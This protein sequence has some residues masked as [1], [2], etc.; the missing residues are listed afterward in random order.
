MSDIFI[1]I[2]VGGTNFRLGVVQ[3]LRVIWEKRF[4]ADFSG[5]CR[6]QSAAEAL[7]TITATLNDAVSEARA[8]Y[9]VIRAIGIGFPGFIAPSTKHVISSPNLPHLSNADIVTPL[10]RRTGLS[11][12]LENDASAAAYGEFVLSPQSNG[13][14]IYLGLGTG[15]GG[16]LVLQGKLHGGVHGVAMEIGHLTVERGGRLCGCG[17]RGC[18]E[19]YAS[20]NGVVQTYAELTGKTL[21]AYDI[22]Q[23]AQQKENVAI[24]A[25][26]RAGEYLAGALAHIAKVV[27][28]SDVV[29]GGGMSASWSLMQVTFERRLSEDLI[30]A[31]RGK[32]KV[33]LSQAQDQAGIIG[34]AMLAGRQ[35]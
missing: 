21:S 25:F 8:A 16:G 10:E 17:N 35:G 31:L 26:E 19:Q 29:I 5:V 14:L 15:V 22:A 3:D 27:D 30:P 18:L 33:R 28:V 32:V 12:A 4:P 24:S 13:D 9:P 7:E 34:A 23:A 20:T 1:G 2:D 11:V 6:R